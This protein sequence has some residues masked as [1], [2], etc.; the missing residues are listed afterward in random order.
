[1]S[2]D[3]TRTEGRPGTGTGT[4]TSPWPG[5]ALRPDTRCTPQGRMPLGRM[6]R[7]HTPESCTP[8]RYT[9]A[10]R[11]THKAFAGHGRRSSH[12]GSR[13][14]CGLALALLALSCTAGPAAAS[15]EEH[16]AEQ[17][18]EQLQPVPGTQ[19]AAAMTAGQATAR[20]PFVRSHL[21]HRNGPVGTLPRLLSH[22]RD[23]PFAHAISL[24]TPRGWLGLGAHAAPMTRVSWDLQTP[25]LDTLER[26]AQETQTIIIVDWQE[27]T[28]TVQPCSQDSSATLT[29]ADSG[30]ASG[31]AS[32]TGQA[33]A[34]KPAASAASATRGTATAVPAATASGGAGSSEP[35]QK[36][37]M[38]TGQSGSQTGSPTS[39]QSN[40]QS[41]SRKS[42]A[43]SEG[44][45]AQSTAGRAVPGTQGMQVSGQ[46][47]EQAAAEARLLVSWYE[48]PGLVRLA[49][50]MTVTEAAIVLGSSR[51]AFMAWN[52]LS[53][54]RALLVRGTPVY[55]RAPDAAARAAMARA[56]AAGQAT[57]QGTGQAA[58]T[59][60]V[61]AAAAQTA[62]STASTAPAAS[63]ADDSSVARALHTARTRA[64]AAGKDKT[65]AAGTAKAETVS[66][67]GTKPGT[68]AA[69]ASRAASQESSRNAGQAASKETGQTAP[70]NAGQAAARYAGQ[71]ATQVAPVHTT[72]VLSWQLAPGPLKRQLEGWAARAGYSVVWQADTDLEMA[73][74]AQFAGTFPEVVRALF[75]GLHRSGYPY[76]AH[77][78]HGNQVLHIE[79]R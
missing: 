71:D 34:Q 63:A 55:V 11:T 70:G 54:S 5:P 43:H 50:D 68:A 53:D 16:C 73:A 52:A 56:Q 44:K 19:H 48:A 22:G 33:G 27:K 13:H 57:G 49:R 45:A 32:D 66:K 8:G 59:A 24:L 4:G 30:P 79:D 36:N 41:S 17:R 1:M 75:E 64:Q 9:S 12:S 2:P 6:P 26:L 58:G 61:Q 39:N 21:L 40:S 77:L 76:T 38:K 31:P 78:F 72:P 46:A 15:Y 60:T 47:A 29:G 67:A 23:L 25:W 10:T 3:S 65:Q 35:G 18:A 37:S 20:A 28:F 51:A 74:G 62:A 14:V 42:T 69:T 7:E